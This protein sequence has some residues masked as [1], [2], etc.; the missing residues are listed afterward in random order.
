MMQL[1]ADAVAAR[2]GYDREFC[3][4]LVR[5][6]MDGTVALQEQDAIGADEVIWRVAHPGGSS[7]KG[8]GRHRPA[9]PGARGRDAEGDGEVVNSRLTRAAAHR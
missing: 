6:T 2:R 3:R 7:E 1:L 9:L 5:D 8:A 4:A